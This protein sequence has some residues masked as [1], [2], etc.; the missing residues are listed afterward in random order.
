MCA[1]RQDRKMKTATMDYPVSVIRFA[2]IRILLFSVVFESTRS[3]LWTGG[4]H[5]NRGRVV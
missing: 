3:E 5:G 1:Q 4:Y 2:F